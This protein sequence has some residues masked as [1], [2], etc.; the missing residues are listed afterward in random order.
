[1]ISLLSPPLSHGP[2]SSPAHHLAG[3]MIA[4]RQAAL[5]FILGLYFKMMDIALSPA[6]TSPTVIGRNADKADIISSFAT[7]VAV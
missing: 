5:L 7:S 6:N 1:M 3:K 2:V 4:T